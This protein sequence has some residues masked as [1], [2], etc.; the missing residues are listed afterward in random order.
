MRILAVLLFACAL[1]SAIYA[2]DFPTDGNGLLDY[3]GVL[4]A[5]GDSRTSFDPSSGDKFSEKMGQLNWCAGYL[6]ALQDIHIEREV[7]LAMIGIVG[8]TLAGPDKAKEYAFDSLRGPCI[9]D[10]AP[11]LKLAVSSLSGCANIPKDCMN[12]GAF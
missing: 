2:R 5:V 11:I 12:L 9:P 7:N 4:V 1:S 10:Q 8:V 3:C 6:G